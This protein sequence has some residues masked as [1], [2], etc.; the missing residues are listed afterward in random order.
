MKN[1]SGGEI[2]SP[3]RRAAMFLI[4][5]GIGFNI[6]LG[7]IILYVLNETTEDEEEERKEWKN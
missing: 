6:V 5:T 7:L 2:P 4:T 1:R 3:D